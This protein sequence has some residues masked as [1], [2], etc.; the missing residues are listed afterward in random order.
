[1]NNERS[2]NKP[3]D[4]KV[5]DKPRKF[6]I[7]VPIYKKTVTNGGGKKMNKALTK[8]QQRSGVRRGFRAVVKNR[9]KLLIDIPDR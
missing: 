1:M 8:G 3:T 5:W 4:P 9:V 2:D 7:A 6:I